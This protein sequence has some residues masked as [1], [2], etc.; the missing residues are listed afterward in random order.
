MA[1]SFSSPSHRLPNPTYRRATLHPGFVSNPPL[2][3]FHR[4]SGCVCVTSSAVPVCDTE[5]AGEGVPP[6][7]MMPGPCQRKK[8]ILWSIHSLEPPPPATRA[9]QRHRDKRKGPTAAHTTHG[10]RPVDRGSVPERLG[11]REARGGVSEAGPPSR[12]RPVTRWCNGNWPSA[13]SRPIGIRGGGTGI[14]FPAD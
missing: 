13:W 4:I 8:N 6:T 1:P 12:P 14:P 10:S 2:C 7:M 9:G 11:L 5:C 3:L